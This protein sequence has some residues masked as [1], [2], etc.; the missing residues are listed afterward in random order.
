MEKVAILVDVGYVQKIFK[1]RQPPIAWQAKMVYDFSKA[2][3][4]DDEK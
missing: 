1:V 2:F 4:E 3:L